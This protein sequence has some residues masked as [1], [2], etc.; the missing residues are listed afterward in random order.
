MEH[1][2]LWGLQFTFYFLISC[3]L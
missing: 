2:D 1:T 3:V